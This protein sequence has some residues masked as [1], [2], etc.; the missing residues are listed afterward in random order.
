M[1]LTL[2][3]VVLQHFNSIT[4]AE[5]FFIE[6]F[7]WLEDWQQRYAFIIDLGKKLPPLAAELQV[8]QNLVRGCQ[9]QVW[10]AITQ[11]NSRLQ[12]AATSDSLIVRGLIAI[13]CGIYNHQEVGRVR[14]YDHGFVQKL[15][16]DQHL[17]PTRSNGLHHMLQRVISHAAE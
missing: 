13:I 16:L 5:N 10:M 3:L 14:H 12:I 15:G 11:S 2:G 1:V 8:E 7:E 4:E 17:S 6:Q 9:S